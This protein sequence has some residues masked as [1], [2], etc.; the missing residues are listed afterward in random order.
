MPGRFSIG[1]FGN[2]EIGEVCVPTLT[3]TNV[4]A[5]EIGERTA[6]LILDIL[7]GAQQAGNVRISPQLIVRDSSKVL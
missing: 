4:F 1:G 2:Y 5:R 3:T 7:D 6:E